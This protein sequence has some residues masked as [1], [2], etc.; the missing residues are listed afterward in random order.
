MRKIL[1]S[2]LMVSI[3][4]MP[5]LAGLNFPDI[6]V[7]GKLSLKSITADDYEFNSTTADKVDYVELYTD[8][9]LSAKL[10]DDVS[11]TTVLRNISKE[12]F[13]HILRSRIL[14]VL[15]LLLDG[16]T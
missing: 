15:T 11:V 3:M 1:L 13:T 16:R 2:C 10:T 12:G 7:K 9:T 5:A 6:D 14:P 8:L 4:A